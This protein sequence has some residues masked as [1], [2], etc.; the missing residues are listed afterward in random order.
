MKGGRIIL[1]PPDPEAALMYKCFVANDVSHDKGFTAPESVSSRS[2]RK[3]LQARKDGRQVT[4]SAEV[5]NEM[6]SLSE[7]ENLHAVAMAE[8]S[9]RLVRDSRLGGVGGDG[10][11]TIGARSCGATADVL[12]AKKTTRDQDSDAVDVDVDNELGGMRSEVS[13]SCCPTEIMD[14]DLDI[15]LRHKH[16]MV[17]STRNLVPPV[18]SKVLNKHGQELEKILVKDIKMC[19]Q[20]LTTQSSQTERLVQ[21]KPKKYRYVHGDYKIDLVTDTTTGETKSRQDDKS[22]KQGQRHMSD[23]DVDVE[24][25]ESSEILSEFDVPTGLLTTDL[26]E[27]FQYCQYD[28]GIVS[29]QKPCEHQLVKSLKTN[30][31]TKQN[32]SVGGTAGL[33]TSQSSQTDQPGQLMPNTY[34][35]VHSCDMVHVVTDDINRKAT[36]KLNKD[37]SHHGQRHHSDFDNCLSASKIGPVDLETRSRK[38]TSK[39][40][41]EGSL[42]NDE[43]VH[44]QLCVRNKG[45]PVCFNGIHYQKRSQLSSDQHTSRKY[46]G[47]CSS[48]FMCSNKNNSSFDGFSDLDTN[49]DGD[50][51]NCEK[52]SLS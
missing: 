9:E 12:G 8:K 18:Q 34:C 39:G 16:R 49:I 31:H 13:D 43:H 38:P 28:V 47:K 3:L 45:E 48:S 25:E 35:L 22:N 46:A 33:C 32:R 44:S 51:N 7:E 29:D 6:E 42:R 52:K 2:R 21:R 15:V 14:M 19:H 11:T 27:V 50:K 40:K 10:G 5:C 41:L 30:C 20:E 23:S 36:R 1:I 4:T 24:F 37:H 17:R 26:M